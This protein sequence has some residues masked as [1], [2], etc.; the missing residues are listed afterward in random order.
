[1]KITATDLARLGVV[2]RIVQEPVG[3]A[4]RD[5]ATVMGRLSATIAAELAELAD[6]SR[7]ALGIDRRGHFM[8]IGTSAQGINVA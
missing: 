8:K 1:M 6:L 3:G 4:H 2:H 5:P 7:D